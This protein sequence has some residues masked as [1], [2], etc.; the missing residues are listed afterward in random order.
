MR[1][2]RTKSLLESAVY[3]SPSG[4]SS[5]VHLAAGPWRRALALDHRYE[6]ALGVGIAVDVPLGCLNGPMASQELNVSQ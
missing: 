1:W 2:F 3:A 4:G 6:L 5:C